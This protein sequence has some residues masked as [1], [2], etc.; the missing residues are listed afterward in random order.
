MARSLT[1]FTVYPTADGHCA[2]AAPLPAQWEVVCDELERPDLVTDERSKTT[3]RRSDN[4]DWINGIM[5]EWTTRHTTAEIVEIL[6]GRVPVGP[7]NDGPALFQ[8]EHVKARSML[9]EVPH[10]GSQRTVVMPNTPVRY[11]ATPTG[12]YRRPPKL[13]EHQ[14]ELFGEEA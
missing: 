11:S 9:V 14:Q 13:G 7:V 4:R 1:P 8:S 2:I 10:P 12:V 6:G 3:R 5:T